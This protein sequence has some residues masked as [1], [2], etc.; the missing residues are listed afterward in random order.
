[1]RQLGI[2]KSCYRN[3][4]SCRNMFLISVFAAM[5]MF[6]SAA[7]A[8]CEL[9]TIWSPN[10]GPEHFFGATAAGSASMN[11]IIIGEKGHDNFSGAAYIYRLVDEQWQLEAMLAAP[12][13]PQPGV[14]FGKWVD[15]SADGKTI[16]ISEIF[17]SNNGLID[18][19]AAWVFVEE[20]GKWV[21]QQKLTASDAEDGWVFGEKLA[22]SA[23][24]NIAAISATGAPFDPV[25]V[26][27]RNGDTWTEA[28]KLEG[29]GF[30]LGLPWIDVSA[31]GSVIVIGAS[32][33]SEQVT[34]AG[35]IYIFERSKGQDSWVFRQKLYASDPNIHD[36]FG[37]GISLSATGDTILAGANGDDEAVNHA[38]AA[39]I[40]QRVGDMWFEQVK[41]IADDAMANDSLGAQTKL[42]PDGQRAIIMSANDSTYVFDLVDGIWIETMRLTARDPNVG[43]LA[44]PIAI[45]DDGLTALLGAPNSRVDGVLWFGAA[46]LI[47]LEAPL[48]D[49]DCDGKI[50]IADLLAFFSNWGACYDCE[51]LG[52]CPG[53]FDLDCTVGISDLEILLN[54]WG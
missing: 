34:D 27:T 6:S 43:G 33:D 47:D 53:D 51:F 19:G 9:Q 17:D 16:L 7:T 8:Q 24:G 48:G 26:F 14:Q 4:H 37:T 39:Y 45:T 50:S 1:M 21:V 40:F 28:G 42:T 5:G 29:N 12:D 20:G 41:I 10:G 30:S 35:A 25:Y 38:G 11:V 13:G 18:N 46:V 2:T 3:T 31:D 15:M 44:R 36:A 23:D 54:N 49:L 52:G 22:L 32:H